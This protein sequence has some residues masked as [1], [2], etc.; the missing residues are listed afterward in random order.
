MPIQFLAVT[1]PSERRNLS[2]TSAFQ[3]P[4]Q[5]AGSLP[6]LPLWSVYPG[7]STDPVPENS[8]PALKSAALGICKSIP[9]FANCGRINPCTNGQVD[10]FSRPVSTIKARSG[11]GNLP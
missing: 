4:E 9:I 10:D 7:I 3:L 5:N 1:T 2:L 8:L 11:L 6:T